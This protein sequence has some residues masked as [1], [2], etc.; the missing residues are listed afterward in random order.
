MGIVWAYPIPEVRGATGCRGLRLTV[1]MG[2]PLWED[3][4]P[5]H[6]DRVNIIGAEDIS[7][8]DSVKLAPPSRGGCGFQGSTAEGCQMDQRAAKGDGW[9]GGEVARK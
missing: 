4:A 9:D 7:G 1:M 6:A 5:L 3:Q 2:R 8:V